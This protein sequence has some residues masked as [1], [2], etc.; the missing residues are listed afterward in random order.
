MKAHTSLEAA[1]EAINSFDGEAENF[2]LPIS[3]EM[4]DAV[5]LNMAI[6]TDHILAK[7]W[8]PDNFEQ[9]KGFRIYRYRKA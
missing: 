3:D 2:L 8:T 9:R 7:G 1:L 4:N 6:I 5:G